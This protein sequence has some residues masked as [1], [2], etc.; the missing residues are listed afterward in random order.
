M[1]KVKRDT[2]DLYAKIKQYA[3]DGYKNAAQYMDDY[4][5]YLEE[6]EDPRTA[7]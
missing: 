3:D 2:P 5:G 4:V 1:A 7:H 6:I